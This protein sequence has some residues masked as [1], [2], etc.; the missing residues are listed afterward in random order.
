VFNGFSLPP[1]KIN[2]CT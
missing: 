1:H 2:H